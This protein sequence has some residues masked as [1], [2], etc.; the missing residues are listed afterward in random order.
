MDLKKITKEIFIKISLSFSNYNLF[1]M[2][3]NDLL[4]AVK[5]DLIIIDIQKKEII[6]HIKYNIVGEISCMYRLSHNNI[7]FG[8]WGNHFEQVEYD[9]IQKDIKVISNNNKNDYI[10]SELISTMY[11]I[12]SIS[13]FNNNLIIAPFN[14]NQFRNSSLIIYQLKNN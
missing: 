6:K 11:K 12:S 1:L 8:G 7:L 5:C 4:L 13:V 3:K 14:N 9:E 10:S 2:N